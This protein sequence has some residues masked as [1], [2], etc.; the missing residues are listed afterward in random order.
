[1]ALAGIQHTSHTWVAEA[2]RR[3]HVEEGDLIWGGA[4]V[5]R[6]VLFM[7][8]QMG[9]VYRVSFLFQGAQDP[10]IRR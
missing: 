7:Q 1:V 2:P 3:M 10:D 5:E 8:R 9:A 4:T 6:G